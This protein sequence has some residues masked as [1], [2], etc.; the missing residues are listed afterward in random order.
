MP[1]R[2]KKPEPEKNP[3]VS[4]QTNHG[5]ELLSWTV[6][7]VMRDRRKGAILAASLLAFAGLVYFGYRD[8]FWPVVALVI[9]TMSFSSFLLPN[10]Y[11]LTTKG[12]R[13][14]NGVSEIFRPWKNFSRYKITGDGIYLVH[15][16]T[17]RTRLLGAGIFMYF[18]DN[19]EE[20]VTAIVEANMSQESKG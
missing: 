13:F 4:N 12:L 20:Q 6:T 17:V 16:K 15:Q 5:E 2:E 14:K 8:W 9:S 18:G 3:V 11:S 19:N 1:K 10:T 7:P